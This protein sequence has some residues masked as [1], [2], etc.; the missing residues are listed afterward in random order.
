MRDI[1]TLE[2]DPGDGDDFFVWQALLE[3]VKAAQRG[4]YGVGTVVV[5]DDEIIARGG[6]RRREDHRLKWLGHA[7]VMTLVKGYSAI[8]DL[9]PEDV[10][11]FSTLESC[12]MCTMAIINAHIGR[13]VFG[14]HDGK[15]GWI[16]G[17]PRCLTPDLRAIWKRYGMTA[18]MARNKRLQKLCREL[19]LATRHKLHGAL[20]HTM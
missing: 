18:E 2:C 14:S 5:H 15:E 10:S 4:N 8:K 12:R 20:H 19:F 6:N 16:G 1:E 9:P 7:E 11:V 3:G 17:A 13:I